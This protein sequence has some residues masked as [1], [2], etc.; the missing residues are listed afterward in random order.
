[1]LV[2]RSLQITQFL[3]QVAGDARRAGTVFAG[4]VNRRLNVAS[5]TPA[6]EGRHSPCGGLDPVLTVSAFQACGEIAL[7]SGP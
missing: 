2:G 5:T 6:L 4:G 1:M 7:E 3:H